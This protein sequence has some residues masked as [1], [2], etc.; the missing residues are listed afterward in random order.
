MSQENVEVVR[1]A[2]A[3][4]DARDF[5]RVNELARSDIEWIPDRRVGAGPIRG[6]D[7]VIEFF[8]GRASMFGEIDAELERVW[9]RGDQVLVFLRLT[10]S[11]VASGAGFDI[12]IAHLWTLG[13]GKLV[14]GQGF[15]DRAEALGASG[16]SE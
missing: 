11:G 13:D 10:G 9:D 15:G 2:Y 4:I 6:R 3:A 16:L 8:T 12:R 7:E 5:R 1:A 14:R